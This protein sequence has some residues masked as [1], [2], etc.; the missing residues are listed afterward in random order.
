VP[1]LHRDDS[2]RPRTHRAHGLVASGFG[3]VDTSEKLRFVVVQNLRVPR[4]LQPPER[5]QRVR[6][7]FGE[8]A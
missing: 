7:L 8:I 6:G 2:A 5:D 3:D 4:G 1:G